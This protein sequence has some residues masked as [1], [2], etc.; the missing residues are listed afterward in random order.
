MA[1]FLV[2]FGI[3]SCVLYGRADAW[4]NKGRSR[5]LLAATEYVERCPAPLVVSSG[6]GTSL[7]LAH[8]LSDRTRFLLVE[9]PQVPV[10]PDEFEDVFLWRVSEA[11]LDRLGDSGWLLEE[12]GIQGLH[13]LS[14]PRA[15][16]V[17]GSPAP[18]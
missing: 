14:R 18:S 13:R 8:A 17:T 11:M 15:P 6:M 7:S 12:V 2:A 9:D 4:W 1:V 5:A 3:F 16:I 10:I